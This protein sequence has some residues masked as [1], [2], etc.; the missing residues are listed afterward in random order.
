[1]SSL[2][3]G[4]RPPPR[5]RTSGRCPAGHLFV[6]CS[7]NQRGV[8]HAHCSYGAR[9]AAN[10]Q[11][12]MLLGVQHIPLSS[13]VQEHVACWTKTSDVVAELSKRV[14][15]PSVWGLRQALAF[16]TPLEPRKSGERPVRLGAPCR[17]HRGSAGASRKLSIGPHRAQL[18]KASILSAE[19]RPRGSQRPSSGPRLERRVCPSLRH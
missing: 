4:Q 10:L 14:D 5:L 1:M 12:Y 15:R 8:T 7:A 6:R 17:G 16:A 19:S 9:D 2:C 11:K 18:G 13:A 3:G